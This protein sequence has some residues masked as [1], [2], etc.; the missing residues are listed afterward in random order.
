MF[1]C[2]GWLGQ[3]P[4]RDS[5]RPFRFFSSKFNPAQLNYST[6]DQELLGVFV[7]VTKMHEHVVGWPFVVVCDH[8]PLK[9][10]W[11]QPPKQT[12]R[13]VRTWEKLAEYDFTWE[14]IPGKR[15]VLADSLSRLAELDGSD[16]VDLPVANEPLPSEDDD[17]P[18][19][20]SLSP[21]AQFA[22][23]GLV[24]GVAARLGASKVPLLSSLSSGATVLTGFDPSF[25]DALRAAT[26]VDPLGA[27]V[28]AAP[29][30]Y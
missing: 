1:G 22:I 20:S 19:N 14:F 2:G 29:S 11:S 26:A 27:K 9:T 24:S 12:R 30:A 8:E 5:A 10:Y 28:L 23:A 21:R 18:F 15:N 16:G 3:G 13:H 25:V 17:E 7:G 4:T 6:T